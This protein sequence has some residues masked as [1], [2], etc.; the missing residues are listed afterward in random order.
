MLRNEETV[1]E[2]DFERV[3]DDLPM[4][5]IKENIVTQISDPL[6]FMTN[7]C[8]QV[9]DTINEAY[10][11]VGQVE[12]FKYR[13]DEEKD[14]FTLFLIEELNNKFNLGIDINGMSNMELHEIAINCYTFFVCDL[15]ENLTNFLL[16]Y[17][18]NNKSSLCDLFVDGYKRKDVTTTNMKRLTKNK[19]DVV[20]MSNIISVIYHI[21][22]LDHQPEDF[23][24]L[25][26]EPGEYIGENIKEA[27]YAFKLSGNFVY[28][29]LS[30][31]TLTHNDVI[32]EIASTIIMEMKILY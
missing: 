17:I 25:A 30:E 1:N 6:T 2:L 10:D 3:M 32:D 18:Y 29:L 23:M 21:L 19:E 7:Q 28:N 22:E 8:E 20:I 13:L 15:K 27:V 16:N 9:Y 31:I 24:E 12:E 5:I 14:K 26:V 4:E 11:E